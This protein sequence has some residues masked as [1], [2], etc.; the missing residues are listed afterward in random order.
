ME[1][2]TRLTSLLTKL[3]RPPWSAE[4]VNNDVNLVN[5]VVNLVV[6]KAMRS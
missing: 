5:N 6:A 4:V 2:D 3:P 1:L